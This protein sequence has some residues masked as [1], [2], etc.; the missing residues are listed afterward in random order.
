MTLTPFPLLHLAVAVEAADGR[1]ARGS[2]ADH[3]PPEWFDKDD[4]LET[5]T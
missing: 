2:A 5:A 1:R 4:S 3:R